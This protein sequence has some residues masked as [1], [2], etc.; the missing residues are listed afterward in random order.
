MEAVSSS[1]AL[2]SHHITTWYHNPEDHNIYIQI[3]YNH[4]YTQEVKT[5]KIPLS[6]N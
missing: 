3:N 6:T 1:E 2:V 5:T 4:Q